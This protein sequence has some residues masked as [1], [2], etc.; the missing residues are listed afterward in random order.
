MQSYS[1]PDESSETLD[2]WEEGEVVDVDLKELCFDQRLRLGVG[3]GWSFTEYEAL[4]EDFHTRGARQEEQITVI[5]KL[6]TEELSSPFRAAGIPSIAS[7]SI[8]VLRARFPFGL[9]ADLA[10]RS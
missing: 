1:L 5:R 4:D 7:V 9:A 8:L 6:W 2:V 10:S 3:I